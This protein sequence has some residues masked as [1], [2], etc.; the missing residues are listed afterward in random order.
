MAI[1]PFQAPINYAVDVQSPFEAV[2][3]GF[4]IGQAGAEAQAQAQ[5][6]EQAKTAQT[7]LTA[8]FKNPKATA[9]DYARVAAFLPKD[10]ADSVRKSFD[11]MSAEQQQSS[12]RN[13]AQVYSAVKSNQIDIAKNLLKE[14]ATA[15][16]NSGREQEAKASENSLQLIELNPTGAQATI[17]VNNSC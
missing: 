14:Q 15:Y 9:T 17:G 8:L 5:A 7:E 1:N 3:S 2:L 11:M 6:R 4:K 12:L 10:Q 16:R 13:A